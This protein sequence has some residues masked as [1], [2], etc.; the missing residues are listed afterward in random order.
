ME[1]LAT[2]IRDKLTSRPTFKRAF[3]VY[4]WVTA[5]LG[6]LF[7]AAPILHFGFDNVW[8]HIKEFLQHIGG[9]LLLSPY[10][11]YLY[12]V[13]FAAIF[14]MLLVEAYRL[15]NKANKAGGLISLLKDKQN[16]QN[17]WCYVL[18]LPLKICFYFLS[19]VGTFCLFLVL[20]SR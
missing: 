11:I 4:V 3:A 5:C 19:L 6:A 8:V 18:F 1:N 20:A 9:L 7:L 16:L 14:C 17:N 15:R 12:F 13:T 10:M 2:C